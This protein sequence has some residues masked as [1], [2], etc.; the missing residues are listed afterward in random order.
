MHDSL[1]TM[2]A[3][4][5]WA[6]ARVA[7]A[8]EHNRVDEAV[9]L[10]AHVASV[11]HL[12]WCRLEQRTPAHAVWPSL[13]VTDARRLAAEHA[14]LFARLVATADDVALL[15]TVAYRN[16]QGTDFT[17]TVGDIVTHT[18]LHGVHHRGQIL[19]ILRA[20]GHE[21][22]YID[23]IQFTRLGQLT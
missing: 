6:D 15:R 20:A 9:R 10:F 8:L 14:D 19:R 3:H 11:E 17:S 16:S 13:S 2:I 12:W 22:P 5:R 7:D 23:Y 21:P 18:A 4:M 1:S